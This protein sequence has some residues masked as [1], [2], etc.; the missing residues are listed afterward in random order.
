[1]PADIF[2][3]SQISASANL[4]PRSSDTPRRETDASLLR[5]PPL[6]PE[7]LL[8]A[9]YFLVPVSILS[10]FLSVAEPSDFDSSLQQADT[11]FF[12]FEAAAP[13]NIRQIKIKL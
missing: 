12:S 8:S 9:G 1:M 6:R 5:R 11:L 13:D 10:V 3:I 4:P 7:T 2:F